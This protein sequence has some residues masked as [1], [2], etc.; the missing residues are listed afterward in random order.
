MFIVELSERHKH[1][2]KHLLHVLE[3]VVVVVSIF[4]QVEMDF[5]AD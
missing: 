2:E 3:L 1:S 5:I 4:D